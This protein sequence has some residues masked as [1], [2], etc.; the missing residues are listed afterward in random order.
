MP[1]KDISLLFV[2]ADYSVRQVMECIDRNRLGIALVVDEQTKL[3]GTI[4]DGD[5]R[6]AV[7]SSVSIEAS[8]VHLLG[9]K[10]SSAPRKPVAASCEAPREILIQLMRDEAVRHV[11]LLN[12]LQQV[13]GMV[14]FDELVPEENVMM[15]AVIMAGGFGSRLRPLTEDMPKPMLLLGDKPLL[16]RTIAQLQQ[17]GIRRVSI[18]THFRPE[19]IT[20]Y[21]GDGKSFGVELNYVNEQSPLGTAGALGLMKLNGDPLLVING[22]ILTDVDFRAMSAYH[23]EH[24][25]DMTVAVR[26]YEV[27]VPYG[28]VECDGSRVTR[29]EE[30]PKLQFFVNA[31]IYM[32]EPHVHASIPHEKHFDMTELIQSLIERNGTVVSFP[33]REY[34]LDIGQHSDYKRAIEDHKAGRMTNQKSG[35]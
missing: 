27:Q 19:K 9:H 25:A 28:V 3:L 31:G 1:S 17:A 12:D 10:T 8:V 33:V 7:L 35:S 20:E 11:P 26:A 5:L 2:R 15:Q 30:K 24:R 21:F 22:D 29:L 18:T 23:R 6:R 32:L 34:W 14:T 4:T 13:V 16:E